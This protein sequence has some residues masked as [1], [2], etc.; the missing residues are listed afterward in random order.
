MKVLCMGET[1][2][3]YSTLKGH[4]MSELDFQ[5]HVGG[6]ETNIAVSLAQ[7]GFD[8][9]LL[10]KLPRHALGDAVISFLK[11]YGVNTSKI[12]RNDM[13]IGSYFLENG[14]GNRSSQVIYDRQYSAMTSFCLDDIVL[15]ELFADIDVFVVSGITVALNETVCKAVLE[16][17]EYCRGNNKLVVYD[18]NYRAKMW[19]IEEAATAFQQ[20]LP[21]VDILSAGVL[22]AQNFLG[23]ISEEIDFEKQLT[24]YYQQM[25]AIYP[26]LQYIT[27]TKRDIIST[28]VNDLTG[29]VYSDQ[30]YVSKTYHID[31]IVDRV[32]GGDAY[33]SGL[34]YGLLNH[35]DIEYSLEFGC[36]ASVLKH[37]IHGDANTFSIAEIESFME[38]GTSRINR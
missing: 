17:L 22:D 16:M 27:C 33:L 2:L 19:S 8:T 37:T 13:R 24:D 14:S 25:K 10:T 34:L 30:L 31:D 4:R 5:V 28:S 1:L 35:R 38:A 29:Y 23:L 15:E 11:K 18:N 3:R 21:Y 6:S 20:I 36:C 26:N 12:L 9:T 32:G 7:Y